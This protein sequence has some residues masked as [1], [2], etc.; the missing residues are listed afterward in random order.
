[1]SLIF[2]FPFT[3]VG[4]CYGTK[5]LTQYGV[6]ILEDLVVMLADTIASIYLELISI[7]SDISTEMSGLGLTLCSMSTRTLQ[8][9]RNEVS[10]TKLV[11]L[12]TNFTFNTVIKHL[13]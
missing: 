11:D 9:L 13:F 7:D 12:L 10:K 1:M 8:K 2:L 4:C 3:S 5:L 6:D